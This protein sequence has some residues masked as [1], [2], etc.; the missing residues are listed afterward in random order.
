[1]RIVKYAFLEKNYD[2]FIMWFKN[3]QNYMQ[4]VPSKNDVSLCLL[5]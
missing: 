4:V 1:M 3:F 2:I 5:L